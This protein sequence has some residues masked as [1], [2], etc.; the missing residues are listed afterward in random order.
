M[1]FRHGYFKDSNG[2]SYDGFWEKDMKHG[3]GVEI[4][5]DGSSYDGEYAWNEFHG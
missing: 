5:K 4:R 3:K 1:K 2:T